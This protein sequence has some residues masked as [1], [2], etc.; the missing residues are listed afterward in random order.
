MA[1]PLIKHLPDKTNFRFVGPAKI[2]AVF[3]VIAVLASLFFTLTPLRPPCGGLNCGVDFRGGNLLQLTT[4]PR[5]LDVN[6]VRTTL[7]RAGFGDVQVQTIGSAQEALVRF[8]TPEGRT[9]AQSV[10]TAQTELRES[11]GPVRFT[12]TESVGARVSKELLTRG[13]AASHESN[14]QAGA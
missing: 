7:D 8:G 6:T 12:R 11:L 5:P 1:W 13:V 2:A 4:A 14:F 9:A 3:S 10:S